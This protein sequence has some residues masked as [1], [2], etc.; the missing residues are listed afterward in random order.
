MKLSLSWLSDYVAHGRT[1]DEVAHLLTMS[2][3]EVEGVEHTGPA[4]GGVV[5]GRV[6]D[7]QPH[8]GAD[9]LRVCQVDLG[10][11][12][13]VQ[14]VCG[15]PNVGA[16]QTVPVA[17]VGTV[18]VLPSRETPGETAPVTIKKSKIRGETSEGMICAE[19]ELGIGTSHDGILVLDA[20]GG[21]A[22]APGTPFADYLDARGL[23]GGDA[24][25]DVNVTPNRPDATSHVGVARD[26]AALTGKPLVLPEVTLPEAGAPFP[27]PITVEDADGCPRYVALVVE[28]VT[29]GPSPAWMRERLEA[30]GVRSINNVVDVTNYVLHET[31]Q[32]LHAFDLDRLAGPEITVR[33][34]RAGETLET[35]DHAERDLPEGTLVIADAAAPVAI[36]GV[37]G[38]AGSEVT[39][40]T[41]RVLIESAAFD[42]P[43][44]RR[45]SKRLGLS[46]DASYR[47]ERGVDETGQLR[48]AARA[49]ALLAEVAGGT[50][51]PGVADVV[52]RPYTPPTTTFRL[53]RVARVLGV[54]VPADEALRLLRAIG[55]ETEPAGDGDT[56]A[57]TIPPWRPDV[58]REVDV[59]E[60]VA[61]L[62]G[63]DRLPDV[64]DVPVALAPVA[65]DP[66][67]GLL[68]RARRRLV[69]LG[70]HDLAT[71]SL[72]PAATAAAYADAAW[73]GNERA[74][75]ETL[76][77]ISQEMAALRPSLLPGLVQAAAYNAARGADALRLVD[78]GHVYARA[79]EGEA[80][81][82]VGYHEHASLALAMAGLAERGGWDRPARPT[83]VFDLKGVVLDVL[84]DLG[85]SDV[86][87]TP[88]PEASGVAAYRLVLS[89]GGRRLGVLGRLSDAL[90]EA[91]GLRGELFVAELDGPALAGAATRGATARYQPVSRH[92]AV[93]RDVAV[94]VPEGTAVGPLLATVREAGRPL[95]TDARLFD[96]YRGDRIP[97]GTQSL[98]FAL[99]FGSDRTLRDAEVD[100]RVRR[101]VAA[102]ERE[103]GAALRQ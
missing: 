94:V 1:A 56:F 44:V 59:I 4:F 79:G 65:E 21:P 39:D 85:I 10:G 78:V 43:S 84:A 30:V 67:H 34:S 63:L 12:A 36:A 86:E 52:S 76:N 74:V 96:V 71:N 33:R 54:A 49:A 77:P 17:T 51:A 19:D 82:I 73:T 61:R 27:V 8:P 57:V 53:S 81:T 14:I 62:V 13:P 83:D 26:V 41:T 2:G 6:L 69:V 18:L 3:L 38:G 93:E 70:F 95:L 40:G 99:R 29:V 60:E 9:R 28:G 88:H 35:L 72:V 58:A 75:V 25:L 15:A 31:G 90:A 89:S 7:A 48:A 100:G 55:F 11:D 68:D 80:T 46:T 5:V 32:P 45:A 20:D 64:A 50:L 103:H 97:A 102:L 37:M 66:L 23:R 42:A 47:F 22:T 92:P 16:G 101:V 91:A 87:E 24:V 98:A